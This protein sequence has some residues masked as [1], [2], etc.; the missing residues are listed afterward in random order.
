[1][2]RLVI[3]LD[4]DVVPAILPD[5]IARRL[6]REEVEDWRVHP[7]MEIP[8]AVLDPFALQVA[9]RDRPLVRRRA[10]RRVE[11]DEIGVVGESVLG[12]SDSVVAITHSL[13][14][15][16]TEFLAVAIGR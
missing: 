6:E 12:E 9:G 13:L 2:P 16:E 11:R 15:R 7:V 1:M 8:A 14:G 5:R 4:R 10:D 3:N